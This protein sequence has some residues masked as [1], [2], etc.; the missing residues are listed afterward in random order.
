MRCE[1]VQG[2]FRVGEV[3]VSIRHHKFHDIRLYVGVPA[4][5]PGRKPYR[6]L[7]YWMIV[8]AIIGLA[9]SSILVVT[10]F[11][12]NPADLKSAA[13]K[14]FTFDVLKE[15]LQRGGIGGFVAGL[16][17]GS[18]GWLVAEFVTNPRIES[19]SRGKWRTT[20]YTWASQADRKAFDDI[21]IGMGLGAFMVVAPIM[22]FL[23]L[24]YPRPQPQPLMPPQQRQV[25]PPQER[26][27]LPWKAD[28]HEKRPLR[29]PL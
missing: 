21:T 1:A 25:Q 26:E 15:P 3:E 17:V 18:L 7:G 22:F 2:F 9:F 12:L 20:I 5:T 6:S 23:S 13:P 29:S 19:T 4:M 8:G 11:A 27:I 14:A 24:Y 16:M 28:D 10:V